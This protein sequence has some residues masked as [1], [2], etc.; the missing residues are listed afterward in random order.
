MQQKKCQFKPFEEDEKKAFRS[1]VDF[2]SGESRPLTA[3][4]DCIQALDFVLLKMVK[5]GIIA[6]KDVNSER[7][8]GTFGFCVSLFLEFCWQAK[9]AVNPREHRQYSTLRG[10]LQATFISTN[11]EI[12]CPES[13]AQLSSSK[14]GKAPTK[15]LTPLEIAELL[16]QSFLNKPVT[17]VIWDIDDPDEQVLKNIAHGMSAKKLGEPIMAFVKANLH[18]PLS[19]HSA[20]QNGMRQVWGMPDD[21][22]LLPDVL[23]V[24]FAAIDQEVPASWCGFAFDVMTAFA[25]RHHFVEGTDKVPSRS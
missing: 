7:L 12:E 23:S 20:V 25:D 19:M 4:D 16:C 2:A 24:I 13:F 11:E 5:S 8:L 15:V 14:D 10:D 1:T 9:V 17:A 22:L 21:K 18:L 3:L 6:E